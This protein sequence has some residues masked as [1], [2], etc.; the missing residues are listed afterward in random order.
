[1]FIFDVYVRVNVKLE[2]CINGDINVNTENRSERILC[3]N[4]INT[5]LNFDRDK[6]V[7]VKCEQTSMVHS[8]LF[9]NVTK[10]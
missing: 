8:D 3:L 2:H 1:M 10:V 5:M 6:T 9:R 7:D 4:A